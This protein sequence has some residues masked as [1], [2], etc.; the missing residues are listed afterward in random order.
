MQ[1][2]DY[3]YTLHQQEW[4]GDDKLYKRF[5]MDVL[6]D[7][8]A[9]K[10][11]GIR[12]FRD[13]EMITIMVPGNKTN[14]ITREVRPEDRVR[15][16]KEYD[17]FKAGEID[18][19]NGFPLKEWPALSRAQIEELKY[20]GF[21]TVEQLA[22]MNDGVAGRHMGYNDLK[23]KAQRWLDN[24]KS[25]APLEKLEAAVKDRE[26]EISALQNQIAEQAKML[27]ELQAKMKGK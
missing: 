2:L 12:K 5:F 23:Q 13:T 18:Q 19:I 16:A 8:I 22:N 20:Q 1:E 9:S 26:S 15:F 25:A 10:E 3:D 24:Q 17:R 27:A 6:E 4:A 11:A 7:P 14:V 21:H